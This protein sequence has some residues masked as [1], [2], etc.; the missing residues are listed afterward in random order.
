M[1]SAATTRRGPDLAALLDPRCGLVPRLDRVAPTPPLPPSFIR[2]AA[3]PADARQFAGWQ[4]DLVAGGTSFGDPEA[5]RLAA[6][7]ESLERYCGNRVPPDLERAS[8][9]GLAD[10]GRPAID[11]G[12]LVLYSERQHRQPDFPFRPFDRDLPVRWAPGR[13]MATGAAVLV[14]ASLV[15]L[16]YHQGSHRAEPATNFLVY[17]G[18]ACGASLAD[19]ERRALEE[20]LERDA[21]MLWWLSGA[22]ASRIALADLPG[23]AAVV[24][25][26]PAHVHVTLVSVP[27]AFPV[28]VVGALLEDRELGVV[29]L[30][31]AC[32]A[33]TGEAALKALG[34][35]LQLHVYAQGL[36]VPTGAMFTAMA[37]GH[38][39]PRSCKPFR[40]DRRYL[41]SYRPD[42]RDATDLAANIQLYLDPR[43][44]PWVERISQAPLAPPSPSLDPPIGDLRGTYLELLA[45]S[46]LAAVSVDVTTPDVAATGMHVVRVVVPGLVP[47]GPTGLPFL[48]GRRLYEVPV[49]RG[50]VPAFDEDAVVRAPLPYA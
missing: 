45:A 46:G 24:A 33:R 11:P 10:A 1:R 6:I 50:W 16:N 13:D 37:A 49:A 9:Q 38:L 44:R 28:P 3:Q 14:P 41:D 47:N 36:V 29:T 48:G 25:E 43:T 18:I 22:V 40:A 21:V 20:L 32:R 19:A 4:N 23:A 39:D 7:G 2:Y 30:G 31:T 5:A 8:H 15:Y 35:A 17:A 27:G 42:L 12:T 26:M 34:E